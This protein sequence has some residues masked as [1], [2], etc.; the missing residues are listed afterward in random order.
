MCQ[1]YP[2]T[3]AACATNS[4]GTTTICNPTT[5]FC[6][7]SNVCKARVTPAGEACVASTNKCASTL[8]CHL[9][10]NTCAAVGADLSHTCNEDI[11]CAATQYCASNSCKDR[12]SSAAT[13]CTADNMCPSGE[14]CSTGNPRT[15]T[16][17]VITLQGTCANNNDAQCASG[18]CASTTCTPLVPNTGTCN[19]DAMCVSGFCQGGTTCADKPSSG[20]CGA[21]QP[22]SGGSASSDV[23]SDTTVCTMGSCVPNAASGAAC[24]VASG[25]CNDLFY[26][27]VAS[28]T[29]QAVGASVNHSCVSDINCAATQYCTANKVCADK[30]AN[31]ATGCSGDNSCVDG[32]YCVSGTNTCTTQTEV[33]TANSCASS[34]DSECEGY[35]DGTV[36]KR[37]IATGSSTACT[38]NS[39]CASGLCASGGQCSDPPVT[40]NACADS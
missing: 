16:T 13:G 5:H 33:L 20:T 38:K 37:L 17:E 39:Q 10:T 28:L 15:C 27:N 35:C 11:N 4:A 22:T 30:L 23:C 32:T 12:L 8:F 21:G 6:N 40:P 14:F 36:C 26:C 31:G 1:D 24:V 2:A 19:R 9:S 18:Y 29:C 3:D 25:Q 7:G 34:N